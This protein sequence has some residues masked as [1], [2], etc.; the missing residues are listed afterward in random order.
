MWVGMKLLIMSDT[1]G[2]EEIIERVKSYHP[3]A[4]RII[5]CGDS[6]LPYSH[7]AMQ[8]MERVKGNC[9]Y[10]QNYLEE[11]LFQVNGERVYVTHGHLYDVKS[12][13]MKL[14][15]RAKELGAN[16]VCF[17]HSHILGAEYIDGIFFINPGSLKKPRQMKEKSFVT[18]T[19][20]PT[21][22]ALDCYDD[23]NNLIEQM[24]IER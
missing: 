23:Q 12:S 8:D 15:Y 19:I 6:E 7:A 17:G 1:H 2:D 3:D 14:V 22:Y 9:D 10:D 11:I 24:F 16:I 13:P 4:Y 20:S 18:L 5:H 21:H